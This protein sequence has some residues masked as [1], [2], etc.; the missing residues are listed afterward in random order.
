MFHPL[1]HSGESHERKDSPDSFKVKPLAAILSA[2]SLHDWRGSLTTF[3]G[4]TGTRPELELVNTTWDVIKDII[5]P[6]SPA[7]LEDKSK[8][9]YVVPCILKDAPLVGNTLEA[10]K[11]N[12]QPTIGRM[13]S[14]QHVTVA[15]LLIIDIDGLP[16][17]VLMAVFDKLQRDGVTY[18]AYTT[19]SHGSAEKPGMRV[20]LVILLDRPVDV[21]EYAAAWHGAD[22]H[23]LNGQA[24]KADSSGANMYQQQGTWCAHSSRIHLSATWSN[25]GGIASADALIGIGKV[26]MAARSGTTAQ[27]TIEFPTPIC[28]RKAANE[29]GYNTID[30]SLRGTYPPSDANKVADL[31]KQIGLF[32]DTRGKYQSEPLWHDCLGV[33]GFCQ[34]GEDLCH[35]WSSG[36]PRYDVRQTEEKL[37]Y[38]LKVAPTTCAQFKFTK[39]DGC[40]SCKRKCRSPITLGWKEEFDI[41]ETTVVQP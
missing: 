5:A 14:K 25:H 31:C 27:A 4:F 8:G 21:A 20:R 38:R 6:P 12:G 10:A 13:R 32:R 23:Y 34:D 33:V 9:V 2:M 29:N 26:A 22:Q 7:L 30:R 28:A 24:G 16:E 18:L 1:Q 39:P 17:T 36:H 19:H 3:N 41:V 11:R 37:A 35:Q 15:R 40:E